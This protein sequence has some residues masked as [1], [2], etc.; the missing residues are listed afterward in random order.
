[1]KRLTLL[2]IGFL[3]ALGPAAFAGELYHWTALATDTHQCSLGLQRFNWQNP[4]G[5]TIY[6]RKMDF[7]TSALTGREAGI[8]T[9]LDP[10]WSQRTPMP[11]HIGRGAYVP[12]YHWFSFDPH[13]VSFA[14]GQRLYIEYWCD[15]GV[16][17]FYLTLW[18][19]LEP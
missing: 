17:E 15:Q 2:V 11:F 6:L 14:P 16:A 4:E 18:Y 8:N 3:L 13:Y 10:G 1:M 12:P 19:T 7:F 9:Y 5:R